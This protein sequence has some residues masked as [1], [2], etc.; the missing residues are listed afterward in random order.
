MFMPS[1][2]TVEITQMSINGEMYKLRYNHKIK[3]HSVIEK[4]E[5]LMH[6]ATWVNLKYNYTQLKKF[7]THTHT[8]TSRMG[9]TKLW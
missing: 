6:T 8:Q 2:S 9:K 1:C 5:L 4:S 7:Y 3:Y